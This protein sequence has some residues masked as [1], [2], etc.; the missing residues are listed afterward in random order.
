MFLIDFDEMTIFRREVDES[1][2]VDRYKSF[3]DFKEGFSL[4][5]CIL[6]VEVDGVDFDFL[7]RLGEGEVAFVFFNSAAPKKNEIKVP[8]FSSKGI[9]S[10][11][12]STK[13]YVSDPFM[14]ISGENRCFWYLSSNKID[15][16]EIIKKILC[17][18]FD[19]IKIKRILFWGSSGG[20]CQLCYIL[21]FLKIHWHWLMRLLL[22]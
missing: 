7:L 9:S 10:G 3:E 19:L 1:E 21:I 13:I 18:L 22:L 17:H 15:S 12:K 4:K 16:Q 6:S 8:V 5:N 20:G 11:L 14:H 2:I